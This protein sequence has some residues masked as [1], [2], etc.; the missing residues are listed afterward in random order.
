MNKV[1][2]HSKMTKFPN[3]SEECL[4]PAQIAVSNVTL[5]RTGSPNARLACYGFL[6]G[7]RAEE[8]EVVG[9]LTSGHCLSGSDRKL[10]NTIHNF[11]LKFPPKTN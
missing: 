11:K 7:I 10:K 1:I 5:P 9:V 2:T 8:S 6:G 3:S 4:L